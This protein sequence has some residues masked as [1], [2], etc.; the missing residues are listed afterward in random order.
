[1]NNYPVPPSQPRGEV[2]SLALPDLEIEV[3][4]IEIADG[5][6]RDADQALVREILYGSTR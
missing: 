2:R 3:E 4:A 5:V 6:V 1:M